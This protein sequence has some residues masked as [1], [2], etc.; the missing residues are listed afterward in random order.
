MLAT[1][2]LRTPDS[3]IARSKSKVKLK[4]EF[5]PQ[6]CIKISLKSSY[7]KLK[8]L[9]P[10]FKSIHNFQTQLKLKFLAL[11]FK[12]LNESQVQ[13]QVSRIEESYTNLNFRLDE[14]LKL[15]IKFKVKIHNWI[16]KFEY[17]IWRETTNRMWSGISS[18]FALSLAIAENNYHHIHAN[19]NRRRCHK[20]KY[21][22]ENT[23]GK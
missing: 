23:D 1:A 11:I 13:V 22:R 4:L 7:F 17:G 9:L 2:W 18:Q 3:N 5:K 21:W 19:A 20:T 10:K 16:L 12:L 14:M 8:T 6:I 15:E